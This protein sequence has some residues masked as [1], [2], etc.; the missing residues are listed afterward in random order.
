M[1]LR[2]SLRKRRSKHLQTRQGFAS[3]LSPANCCVRTAFFIWKRDCEMRPSGVL[4]ARGLARS[5]SINTD[6]WDSQ[7]DRKRVYFCQGGFYVLS[8]LLL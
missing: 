6:R 5:R 8:A 1:L 4:R 3:P 2:N 7:T